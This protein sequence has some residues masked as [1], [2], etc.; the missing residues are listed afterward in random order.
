[1]GGQFSTE[2]APSDGEMTDTSSILNSVVEQH[3]YPVVFATISGAH[4]YGFPSPDS[5]YDLRG[6]HLLPLENIVGFD[7]EDETVS[8]MSI[9]ENIELDLVTH[10]AKKFFSLMLKRNG[11]VL[12]QLYSPLVVS[13]SDAHA[14]LKSLGT[15]CT[16]KHHYHHY[17]GFS[18][19]QW[20]MFLC[21]QPKRI[22]PLLYVYRVL[23]TGIHLLNTGRIECDITKLNDE[24]KPAYI[25]ELVAAKRNGAEQQTVPDDS[26]HLYQRDVELLF[27]QLAS[28]Y[29][30]STLPEAPTAKP[31]LDDLLKRLRLGKPI[32]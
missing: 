7:V 14:E 24:W 18:R 4:L 17:H 13:T 29:A 28:A 21:E 10:D 25:A 26:L 8:S 9:K 19:N 3:Q 6:V 22:K 2:S 31:A 11:Y 30:S 1:V 20:N 5:D 27:Q 12:E 32:I 23:L 16:T 15:E